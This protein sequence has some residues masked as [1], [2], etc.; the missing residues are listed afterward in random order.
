MTTYWY[1]AMFSVVAVIKRKYC[2]KINVEQEIRVDVSN[3]IPRF[4]EIS[5]YDLFI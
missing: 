3:L 1:K 4:S 5:N 2:E